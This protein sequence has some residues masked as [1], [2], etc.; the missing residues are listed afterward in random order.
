MELLRPARTPGLIRRLLHPALHWEVPHTSHKLFLTFDDGP[1]PHSTPLLLKLLKAY[2]AKACFFCVGDNVRK[3]PELAAQIREDGHSLANHGYHH[4]NGWKTDSSAYV[5]DVQRASGLIPLPLFRPPYGR[6][7]HSQAAL[8]RR[9]YEIV[10]W[11]SLSWD[12][13]PKVRAMECLQKLRTG[14]RPGA[15]LGLHDH[16]RCVHTTLECLRMLLPEINTKELTF[17]ALSP[18]DFQ[19]KNPY[20]A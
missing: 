1:D 3:Y 7:N 14:I 13:H 18:E 16:P 12:F 9:D 17:A 4:L 6:I 5:A 20:D 2:Q 19:R 11:T 15:I 8:L 10:M